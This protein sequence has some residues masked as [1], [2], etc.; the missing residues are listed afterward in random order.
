MERNLQAGIE[1]IYQAIRKYVPQDA[2]ID[3]VEV[4]KQV[5]QY[6]QFWKPEEI[7]VVLLAESHV[8]TKRQDYEKSAINQSWTK[9]S[10]TTH[11][12]S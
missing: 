8:Y 9:L 5:E 11:S 3:S 6:R 1:R 12:T 10:E 4:V 7:K 2:P